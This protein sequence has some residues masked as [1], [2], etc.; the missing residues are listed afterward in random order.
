[1]ISA[2]CLFTNEILTNELITDLS[3]TIMGAVNA[4][5][6]ATSLTNHWLDIRAVNKP[7]QYFQQYQNIYSQYKHEKKWILMINPAND[8]L[9]QLVNQ[10]DMDNKK[11]LRVSLKN[12]HLDIEN[13]KNALAKG[14]CS[15]VILSNSIFNQDEINELTLCAAAGE[16]RCIVLNRSI[17]VH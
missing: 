15:A 6:K 9:E 5:H 17:S 1:M 8:S 3:P 11:V 14:N 12:K 13:I 16:T 4:S 7:D 10:H 2:N